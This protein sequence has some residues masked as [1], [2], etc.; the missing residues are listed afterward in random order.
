M[1]V[2]KESRRTTRGPR[3]EWSIRLANLRTEAK[4]SQAQLADAAGVSQS[5][6]ADYETGR[7]EPTFDVVRKIAEVLSVHPA[8]IVFGR[9][10]PNLD[11]GDYPEFAT[12]D[13]EA[14]QQVVATDSILYKLVV[15]LY[16]ASFRE[17]VRLP[18]PVLTTVGM[19]LLREITVDIPA[20]EISSTIDRLVR[21]ERDRLSNLIKR[22][23]HDFLTGNSG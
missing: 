17:G 7:S 23:E 18:V 15:R 9:P 16:S 1:S 12:K 20:H 3:P 19:Q 5:A 14:L 2:S 11:V 21:R 4:L 22:L 13:L 10:S 6:I 8:D